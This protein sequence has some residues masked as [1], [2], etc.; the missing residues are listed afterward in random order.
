MVFEDP[1]LGKIQLM[2]V[3]LL[4]LTNAKNVAIKDLVRWGKRTGGLC[5]A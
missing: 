4:K 5:Y 1:K 2:A 3:P